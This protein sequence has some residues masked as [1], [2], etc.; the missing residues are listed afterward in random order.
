MERDEQIAVVQFLRVKKIPFYA[1]PNGG[2]RHMIEAARMKQEGVS[3]GVPDLVIFLPTKSL[4][5][6]MKRKKGGR[7]S[8][9]QKQWIETINQYPYAHAVVCHGAT[10]AINTIKEHLCDTK[11]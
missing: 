6:E 8:P 4:Y 3:S 1:V 9:T 11:T 2:S 5:I 10:E 7:V